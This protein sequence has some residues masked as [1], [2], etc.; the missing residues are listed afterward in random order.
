MSDVKKTSGAMVRGLEQAADPAA[1]ETLREDEFPHRKSLLVD[2]RTVL[3]GIGAAGAMA[4]LAAAG[5]RFLP[6]RKIVP[7]VRQ[8]ENAVAGQ[9]AAYASSIELGGYGIGVLVHTE[10]G[11]PVRI[12]GHP[13]HPASLG[14][15]DSKTMAQ[16]VSLFDPDRLRTPQYKGENDSWE[17][18][19]E[20]M[21]G[22]LSASGNG[23]GFYLLTET[24]GSPSLRLQVQNFL[25]KYPGAKWR[26]W[27]PANRD[28]VHAG[29]R[30]VYGQDVNLHYDFSKAT[31]VLSVDSNF[32]TEGPG[33]VR[34]S[35]D[36]MAR[37]DHR[38]NP[39]I[40][41]LYA[42]ESV[43][44]NVGVV[45][46]HRA[47]LRA[48]AMPAF[49]RALATKLG[50]AGV[51]GGKSDVD[52]KFFAAVAADLARAG[53]RAVV[54]AG[55]YQSAECHAL[56]ALINQH[57]ASQVT[58]VSAPVLAKH[59]DQLADLADL[60]N[61]M[62]AGQVKGLLM[63]GGNPVY[64]A[65]ADL[66]FGDALTKVGQ[67]AHL[68]AEMNETSKVAGW[69]LPMSHPLESWGDTVA[70]DGTVAVRQPVLLPLFDSRS[71]IE[72][73]DALLGTVRPGEEIVKANFASSHP[74]AKWADFL[75]SGIAPAAEPVPAAP[76]AAAQ[77]VAAPA[78][79]TEGQQ[80][81]PGTPT[82]PVAVP[83]TPSAFTATAAGLG[84][85]GTSNPAMGLEL[86]F[87]P[88]PNIHDGRFANNGWLQELP[89]PMSLLVWDNA[90]YVSRKTADKLGVGQ[91]K[92][93][94]PVPYLGKADMVT[95]TVDGRSLDV[96]VW[97]NL[98]QADDVLYLTLGG[99]RSV[100]GDVAVVGDEFRKGGGFNAYVLRNSKN[101]WLQPQVQAKA[102]GKGY[103]LVSTQ[104]HNMLDTSRVDADRGLIFETTPEQLKA[105]KP[106]GKEGPEKSWMEAHVK[107]DANGETER[108][109]DRP[110]SWYNDK[111]FD[112]SATNYQW[113]MTID[114][115][116][117]TGCNA[118]MTACQ[119]ENNIPVVGKWEAG[120]HR[121]MHWIR[122]DRYYKGEWTDNST[123][124]LDIDQ[125]D[126]PIFFQPV[127]CMH[128]ENAP[129]EPVCPVAATTHSHE[130]LNQM[131]YN[132]CVG[133]RY[134][135][136]NCPYKVRRFNFLD[137][138]A[139]V[140]QVPILRLLQN[141]EVTVRG[142]GVME[143]CTYCVQRIAGARQ[144]AKVEGRKIADGEVKTACQVACPGR[145]IVFGD[146]TTKDSAIV[147][148]QKDPR[149]Y[150]LLEELNTRPRTA[151]L[152][153]V[154]NP[155]PALGG[156]KA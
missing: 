64:D 79:A 42:V 127:T 45:A 83:A 12:E 62:N 110:P 15:C 18:V 134:C 97:V 103:Q 151:Y 100:G 2:R 35:R 135:S 47:R 20:K 101:L 120:K 155:N 16:T 3:K 49:L 129:C 55:E 56:A 8:P 59:D 53:S 61:A 141:P 138:T 80:A 149:K 119:A 57:L 29:L 91:Q 111:E 51:S 22:V 118:C 105:G 41:R 67:A 75:A 104:Y 90:L 147:K 31:V 76:V 137:Y 23:A 117:C 143:K 65:P 121:A 88:D 102:A 152:C 66:K 77:P 69:A 126:P 1:F 81:T 140:D 39:E 19:L 58:A 37:R 17:S 84:A 107:V 52:P 124:A 6:Q 72:V 99:G 78:T 14:S 86:V 70:F 40:A 68:T 115:A 94:G 21:R 9:T 145:A 92:R 113:A 109:E 96:P 4:T 74:G 112:F 33:H 114:L 106:F 132:R 122:V 133:T 50:V 144:K 87:A 27:D 38:L 89:K 116:L 73:L 142:R 60:V 130:G 32:L 153:R 36:F 125:D 34:Y 98:G 30:A 85:L 128:C 46:D 28:Q 95:L 154:T 54:V 150:L 139:K 71:E 10:D 82:P 123:K 24:V 7:Y 44:T 93:I 25:K 11:H 5:C 131:V 43:P 13:E 156:E 63:L 48:S 108:K 136:N 146:M 26:Q 148:S